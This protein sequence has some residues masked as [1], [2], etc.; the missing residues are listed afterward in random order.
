M[1]EMCMKEDILEFLMKFT[2]NSSVPYVNLNDHSILYLVL[3]FIAPS[4]FV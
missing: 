1:H 4:N 3:P 2:M